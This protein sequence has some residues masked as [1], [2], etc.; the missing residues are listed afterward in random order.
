MNPQ[1]Y[2]QQQRRLQIFT[3]CYTALDMMSH[4]MVHVQIVFFDDNLSII[5]N[6]QNPAVD[7]SNKHVA[8]SFHIIRGAVD[9]GI[10]DP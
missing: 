3:I 8:I 5:F 6:T 10:S 2:T 1:Y 7:L 9:A 4:Q